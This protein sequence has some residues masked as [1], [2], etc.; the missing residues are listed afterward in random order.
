MGI[1]PLDKNVG[2]HFYRHAFKPLQLGTHIDKI[3][4]L[5]I[6]RQGH[7]LPGINLAQAKQ[8]SVY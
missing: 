5:K 2:I 6:Y 4:L 1:N 3:L 8:R 7:V